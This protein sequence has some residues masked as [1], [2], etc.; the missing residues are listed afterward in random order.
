MAGASKQWKCP[1]FSSAVFFDREV[2]ERWPPAVMWNKEN[3]STQKWKY[4]YNPITALN[5]FGL[6]LTFEYVQFRT[7]VLL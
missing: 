4:D 1:V 7:Y 6:Q 2:P 5:T 3:L